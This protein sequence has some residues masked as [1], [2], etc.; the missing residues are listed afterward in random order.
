MGKCFEQSEKIKHLHFIFFIYNHIQSLI[1]LILF[2]F[3]KI[4]ERYT[5]ESTK[6]K[7]FMQIIVQVYLHIEISVTGYEK[8]EV[9]RTFLH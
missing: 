4:W 9:N 1:I 2:A 7:I 5:S 3:L 8:K 6:M